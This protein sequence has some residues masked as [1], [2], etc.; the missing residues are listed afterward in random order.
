[1]G[2]SLVAVLRDIDRL[3][4]FLREWMDRKGSNEKHVALAKQQEVLQGFKNE[5]ETVGDDY[6]RKSELFEIIKIE[7]K[8][9]KALKRAVKET[10]VKRGMVKKI[11]AAWVIT[12]P[13]AAVLS[14]MVFFIIKGIWA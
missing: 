12:V 4:G 9:V 11:V 7:K 5:L 10:Y 13:V 2:S 3:V 8:R 6:K 14:A 1:M